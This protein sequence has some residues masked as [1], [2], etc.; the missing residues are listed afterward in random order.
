MLM[1]TR[2]D[3]WDKEGVSTR[4]VGPGGYWEEVGR[5]RPETSLCSPRA[6]LGLSMQTNRDRGC[7]GGQA[8]WGTGPEARGGEGS[9]PR[10]HRKPLPAGMVLDDIS[11]NLTCV[12]VTQ[13]PC[14][15]GGVAY[16]PG[17][18]TADACRTW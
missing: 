13:C 3:P 14:T 11:K 2:A 10:S 12:P 16:A 4:A 7:K 9:P 17:E 6:A 8:S 15:L 18:V 5:A 1:A